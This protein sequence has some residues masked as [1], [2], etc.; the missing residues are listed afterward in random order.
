MNKFVLLAIGLVVGAGLGLGGYWL[1]QHRITNTGSQINVPSPDGRYVAF[2][3]TQEK[4]TLPGSTALVPVLYVLDHTT[5][6]TVAV[7]NQQVASRPTT[8]NPAWLPYD[9][10]R[11]QSLI[12]SADSQ[13]L[14]WTG[15]D[16]CCAKD[17]GLAFLFS[18]NAVSQSSIILNSQ[19]GNPAGEPIVNPAHTLVAWTENLVGRTD[20]S[21][22]DTQRLRLLYTPINTTYG[23]YTIVDNEQNSTGKSITDIAFSN[24]GSSLDYK[25]GGVLQHYTKLST[26]PNTSSSPTG[27]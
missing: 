2:Y 13:N 14:L 27:N 22:Q 23:H 25:V 15:I 19:G 3:S 18:Y 21:T 17:A 24:D 12:W 9:A 5:N 20:L 10:P 11:Y 16:P 26:T 4:F 6:V 1:Y 8:S 7:S